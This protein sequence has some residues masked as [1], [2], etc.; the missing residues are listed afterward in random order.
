MAWEFS[1]GSL[2]LVRVLCAPKFGALMR[3]TLR[4][5]ALPDSPVA[6]PARALV[7]FRAG[8]ISCW[9]PTVAGAVRAAGAAGAASVQRYAVCAA[10]AV[11][12][13]VCIGVGLPSVQLLDW[14]SSS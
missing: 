9:L 1:V 10:G 8:F 13:L 3:G 12:T 5:D 11:H 7:A 2:V 4:P 14:C 6:T